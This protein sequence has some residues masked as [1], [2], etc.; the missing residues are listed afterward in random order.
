MLFYLFIYLF[1]F[2]CV[3]TINPTIVNSAVSTEESYFMCDPLKW[4]SY[5]VPAQAK[6]G[7][8]N[9][10]EWS[11]D[12]STSSND[13]GSV[14]PIVLS[15]SVPLVNATTQAVQGVVTANISLAF[16]STL[17][18]DITDVNT[19]HYVVNAADL[20]LLSNSVGEALSVNGSLFP[21]IF[22][23]NSLI[24][25]S[26]R[27]VAQQTSIPVAGK[28]FKIVSN[29]S[30]MV[31]A[32]APAGDGA[33]TLAM[34]VVTVFYVPTTAAQTSSGSG[35]TNNTCGISAIEQSAGLSAT[36]VAVLIL[37]SAVRP[38]LQQVLNFGNSVKFLAGAGSP[39]SIS[40]TPV[41]L[42]DTSIHSTSLKILRGM[43]YAY[44]FPEGNNY[45]RF[46]EI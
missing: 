31:F 14:Q 22:A 23:Q 15:Y 24:R 18:R 6:H 30:T 11:P 35:R 2:R 3:Q 38:L 16:L 36:N 9:V 8:F 34:L 19:V 13:L 4:D 45:V 32:V 46:H 10:P 25:D 39:L 28:V 21:A 33:Q 27:V 12:D 44:G 41:Q 1:F 42:N 40:P 20:T 26:A 5:S 43:M 37:A 17:F 7:T 29:A